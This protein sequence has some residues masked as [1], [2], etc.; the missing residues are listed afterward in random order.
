[1]LR[2][3]AF[4]EYTVAM[5][6]KNDFVGKRIAVVGIGPH[7]EM[8]TDIKYLVKANA[9]VSV[10]DLRSESRLAEH[11]SSLRSFGLANMVLGYIPADD[12][13]D[14]DVV[15]L[16]HDYPR[17]S[18][19][20]DEVKKKN[21]QIEYPETLFLKSAPPVTVVGVMGSCGKSTV[22]SMM[23]P[24]LT[25]ACRKDGKQNCF[26]IDPDGDDGALAHLKKIKNGDI[27]IM[28]VTYNLVREIVDLK[29][30]PQIA[31]FTA[32]PD[33]NG[34]LNSA[35]VFETIAFQTYN[36]YVIGNDESI[37]AV[38]KSGFHSKAKMIRTKSLSLPENWLPHG[39]TT[40][41]R[42]NAALA[43]EVAKIFKVSDDV[44]ESALFK[45]K[46]LKC[47]IELIKRIRNVDY[48]NDSASVSPRST[49]A[50]IAC[51]TSGK[52]IVLIIGG[53]DLGHDFRELYKLLKDHVHTLVVIPGSGSL[54]ER[55]VLME[56]EGVVVLP[57][58]TLEEAVRIA[59]EKAQKNDIV[60]FSPAFDAVGTDASRRERGERFARAVRSLS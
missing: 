59:S 51:L 37:D 54:K 26:V 2:K 43:L 34:M 12:L 16:S 53:A 55:K 52:N 29:W 31:V 14:M 44:A 46:P 10:Y 56:L 19:F 58:P 25:S 57:A 38:R 18:S 3:N 42:E 39:R 24:L 32:K 17:N 13:L 5:S 40:H 23:K 21:I 7:G 41:D 4:V 6:G 49:I 45:W 20:L 60:L 36:N 8:L 50:A 15:I 1:M 30:S 9:L 48:V 11:I 33:D 47:R 28:R 27:V 22:I 35:V